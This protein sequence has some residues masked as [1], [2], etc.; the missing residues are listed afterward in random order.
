MDTRM[1]TLLSAAALA[2][3]TVHPAALQTVQPQTG[4]MAQQGTGRA[5]GG[6]LLGGGTQSQAQYALH[7]D[8]AV[9]TSGG[10]FMG[11][12]PD[13]GSVGPVLYGPEGINDNKR[14]RLWGNTGNG[15]F[16]IQHR[17][18]NQYLS[19]SGAAARNPVLFIRN[20]L[21]ASQW[22]QL[23]NHGGGFFTV[24]NAATNQYLTAN[25]GQGGLSITTE[26]RRT[27]DTRQ[28]WRITE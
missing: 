25:H 22:W 16:V 9:I 6:A 21:N 20:I 10:A 4:V 13:A 1:L 23:V 15:L 24:R 17:G 28:E 11:W 12:E 27:G 26:A 14:W 7:F 8:R 3:F 5:P 2:V 19:A 18:T